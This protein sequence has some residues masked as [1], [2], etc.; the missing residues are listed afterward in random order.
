MPRYIVTGGTGFLGRRVLP[1]LLDSDPDAE[2]FV[3]VRRSSADKLRTMAE[4]WPGRERLQPLVGD[5]TAPGLGIDTPP[6]DIDDILHLGAVYDMT[7]SAEESE[8]ANVAGTTAVIDLARQLDARLH[9]ISSVAVAGDHPG[10]YTE[11]DFDLGQ[12]LPSPY[13]ATKFAAEK[14]VRQADGLR[15]R[16]YRPSMVVG[17]SRT[18]EMDKIDGPY[19]FFSIL[20]MISRLPSVL[21]AL[22][23]DVGDTNV[24]PVDYV[25]DAIVTL[26][27]APGLDGSAFHLVNPLPQPAP[28]IF[29]PLFAAAGGPR[30]VGSIPEPIVSRALALSELPVVK[31]GRDKILDQLGV[32]P[33]VLEHLS[34]ASVFTSVKTREALGDS[35]PTVPEFSDYADVLWRYWYDHLRDGAR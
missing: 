28:D 18:G 21:P 24:V 29:G 26:A 25:A 17:D 27:T 12:D 7:A 30:V 32:P 19:Y 2:I 6:A 9:H 1:L 35:G 4:K 8:R 14:L 10:P 11:D 31:I 22:I 15:W 23:P 13:H 16:V 33:E 20:E 5:L 3:L 34:F